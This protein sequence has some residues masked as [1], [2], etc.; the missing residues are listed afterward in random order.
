[1]VLYS[2]SVLLQHVR[3]YGNRFF[4]QFGLHCATHQIRILLVSCVVITSLFYPALALYSSSTR[5]GFLSILDVTR[6]QYPQDLEDL[7]TGHDSLRMLG[8]AVSRA[9]TSASCLADRA[10][11][12]ERIFIQSPTVNHHI[13]QSTL[14]LERRIDQLQL[15]CLKHGGGS[16]FVL[17]PLAFWR[18]NRAALRE[19]ANILGTLLTRNATVADIPITPQMVLAG[20]GSDEPRVSGTD[21]DY[22]MF[23][24]LTY[25]FPNS[26]CIGNAEHLAWLHAIDAASLGAPRKPYHS[27]EPMLI[28]LEYDESHSHP[29]GLTAISTL[30]YLAYTGF[31]VYVSWSMRRMDAVHSRIGL[32]FTALVEIAVST[33][34]SISVCAL[35]G[36]KVTMVPWELLP[37]VIVFVG[38]E[39]MFNLVDAVGKTSVT[40]SVKQRIAQGLSHAGTSN[41]LKVVSYNSILGVIAVFAAGAIRQFCVFAI[42]VLVAHWFL[43]HTFFMAVLSID[44]QRLEL[45]DLIRQNP[46][47]APAAPP[48]AKQVISKKSRSPREKIMAMVHSLLRGRAT[49]NISLLMLLAITGTLYYTTYPAEPRGAADEMPPAIG[50]FSSSVPH[51]DSPAWNIWKTLNPNETALHLRI[52]APTVLTFLTDPNSQNTNQKPYRSSM[53]TLRLIFWIFKIM[54]LPITVTTG[55]LWA[56]LLYLRK[57][58]ELLEAGRNRPDSDSCDVEEED[59][60]VYEGRTLFSTLP[61]AFAS[62]VELIASSQDG[63]LIVS[64]G[65]QNEVVIW[66]MPSREHVA[67]DVTDVLLRVP[68]TSSASST[69][70]CIAVD[71]DGQYCAV[72][73]AAGTI[74]VWSVEKGGINPLP[75][76]SLGTSSASVV[77]LQ[78]LSTNAPGSI[79]TPPHSEPCSPIDRQSPVSL[80]ATYESGL[81]TKWSIGDSD[82][83]TFFAPSQRASLVRALLLRTPQTDT[84]FIG[85]CMNDGTLELVEAHGAKGLILFE[86]SFRA[87]NY[88]DVVTKAHVCLVEMG[89]SMRLVVAAAT[90]SGTVSLWDGAGGLIHTIDDVPGRITQLR[91]SPSPSTACKSCGKLPLDGFFLVFSLDNIVHFFRIYMTDETRHCSCYV[92]PPRRVPSWDNLGRHS[93]TTSI[94]PSPGSSPSIPRP[95]LPTVFEPP[96][97]PVSGHGVHSR[98]VSE[99]ELHRRSLEA[100]T[101]PTLGDDHDL[102]LPLD[103]IKLSSTSTASFWQHVFAVRVAD[104]VCD[105]GGWDVS[106]DRRVVGVR[107]KARTATKSPSVNATRMTE[108]S[109]L[110]MATLESNSLGECRNIDNAPGVHIIHLLHQFIVL[111]SFVKGHK[112]STASIAVYPCVAFSDDEDT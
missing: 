57:D 92:K 109:G 78:F 7:W 26:D 37:I 10:L 83:V 74:A 42:V 27:Q 45:A 85:F 21:F 106:S 56:L 38:A 82:G 36:F 88:A 34:T 112:S 4:L 94:A 12:V 60:S 49:K 98:R 20:R 104:T 48:V 5:T 89:G 15:A 86:N 99:K 55:L 29:K 97:F 40:L 30:L 93:R 66:R 105:R 67:I 39:N 102:L 75:L 90:E 103:S 100:L 58:A 41:T 32:T 13:L 16:C 71:A 80:L 76:L 111:A 31:V 1:M 35:V 54:V 91:V 43:A 11:R 14:D 44:I 63:G 51:R 110:T 22:A 9:K 73:T 17:S 96:P 6:S 2:P 3:M 69:L 59:E 72:G 70:T 84:V 46:S 77:D 18:Y 53:R 107:R 61:R 81:A 79:K 47:L 95:T 52:E 65:M 50:N 8:D 68:S 62:D 25:F 101:V 64:V 108:H 87:G 28:S 19:D 24:A 33:I 23:L